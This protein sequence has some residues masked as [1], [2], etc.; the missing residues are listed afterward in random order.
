MSQPRRFDHA[1]AIRLYQMGLSSPDWPEV[2]CPA[3]N[4]ASWECSY[5]PG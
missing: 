3:R 1:E 2:W 5:A 4:G